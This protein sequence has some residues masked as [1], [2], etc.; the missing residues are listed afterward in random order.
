MKIIKVHEDCR[1]V[2]GAN[3]ASIVDLGRNNHYLIPLQ[4]AD[5][6][7]KYQGRETSQLFKDYKTEKEEIDQYLYFLE[8]KE[9]IF[10]VDSR[11][12]YNFFPLLSLE[13]DFPSFITNAIIDI[14]DIKKVTGVL[15]EQLEALGC[16]SVSFRFY[17]RLSLTQLSS[18]LERLSLSSITA[19]DITLPF[20]KSFSTEVITS[21]CKRNPRLNRIFFFNSPIQKVV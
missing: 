16:V 14:V 8:E 5:I 6:L 11:K 19:I 1:V 10:Y 20:S 7:F 3:R 21:L 13:W 4:L 12:E 17:L 2:K 15:L 9:I 18:L